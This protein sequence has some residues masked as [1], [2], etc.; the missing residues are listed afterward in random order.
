M[1]TINITPTLPTTTRYNFV[2]QNNVGEHGAYHYDYPTHGRDQKDNEG[3]V[4]VH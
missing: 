4:L 3:D 1:A 2:P